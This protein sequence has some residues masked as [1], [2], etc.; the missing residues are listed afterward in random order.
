MIT[1]TKSIRSNEQET[2]TKLGRSSH[3]DLPALAAGAS[4]NAIQHKLG[5]YALRYALFLFPS[6]AVLP[7]NNAISLISVRLICFLCAN[8]VTLD[9]RACYKTQLLYYDRVLIG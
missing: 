4:T 6:S 3:D 2:L 9:S 1:N 7:E 8:K 5:G